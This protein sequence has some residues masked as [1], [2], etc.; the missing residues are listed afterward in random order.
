MPLRTIFIALLLLSNGV[1]ATTNT[2]IDY[3]AIYSK[4]L[5]EVGGIN[6]ASV[7]ACSTYTSEAAKKEMTTLYKKI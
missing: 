3:D 5:T 1:S 7:D 4:C 6:N 2:D